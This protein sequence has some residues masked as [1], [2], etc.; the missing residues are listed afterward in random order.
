VAAMADV[1]RLLTA[2]MVQIAATDPEHPHARYC[3]RRYVGEIDARFSAAFDPAQSTLPDAGVLRPPDGLLL[4]ATLHGEPVGCGGLLASGPEA[5]DLKRMWV[6]PR[7]RGLGLGRRLLAELEVRVRTPVVRLETN[8]TLIG[9]I[10][11]YRA[12]GYEEVGAFN[13][14]PCADH[15]FAKRLR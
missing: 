10:A 5:T 2:T 12:A 15:W 9:A 11:M 4:V 6:D 7:V 8:R 3:L 13:D 1:E 14:E